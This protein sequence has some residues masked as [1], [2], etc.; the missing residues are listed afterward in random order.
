MATDLTSAEL[1]RLRA[2]D[3]MTLRAFAET[4]RK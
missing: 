3:G 2:F 4:L 1:A